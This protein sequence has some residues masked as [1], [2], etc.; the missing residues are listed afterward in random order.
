MSGFSG[1]INHLGDREKRGKGVMK[2]WC[3][4]SCKPMQFQLTPKK[5]VKEEI[6]PHRRRKA[7]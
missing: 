2:G 6:I 1:A 4:C 3:P 7:N 5:Q